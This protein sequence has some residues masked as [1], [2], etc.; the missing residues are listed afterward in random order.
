LIREN[1]RYAKIVSEKVLGKFVI[2]QM[3][4]K[5]AKYMTTSPTPT[6]AHHPPNHKSL[7]SKQQTVCRCSP[8]RWHKWR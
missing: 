4:V 1:P 7:L 3:M 8:A 6:G 2:Y 5:D